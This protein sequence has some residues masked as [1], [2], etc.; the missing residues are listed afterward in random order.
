MKAI[1]VRELRQRASEYLRLVETGRT[2]E[3]T[4]RGR[5]VAMLV[6]VQRVG[7]RDVLIAQGRLVPGAGD[8]LALGPPLRVARGVPSPGEI[9]RR[10]R[11]AE[12]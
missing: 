1:G 8:L 11:D 7:R 9:L 10:A 3:V 4:T 5:R 6:P 2:L 12:R